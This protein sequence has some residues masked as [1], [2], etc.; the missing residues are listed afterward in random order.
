MT[1]KRWTV[2]FRDGAPRDWQRAAEVVTRATPRILRADATRAVRMGQGFLDVLLEESEAFALETALK[3]AGF[4]ARAISWAECERA[5]P[6]MRL[7]RLTREATDLVAG[8]PFSRVDVVHM[9]LAEPAPFFLPPPTS[10]ALHTANRVAGMVSSGVQLFGL[11]DGGF[12]AALE[13]ATD[14]AMATAPPATSQPE[15]VIE[16]LGLWAPRVHLPVDTFEYAT[17]GISGGRRSRVAAL[18]ELVVSKTPSARRLGLVQ[19]VLAQQQV[20]GQRPM[21]QADHRRFVMALLTGRRL[22]PPQAQSV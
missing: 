16:L 8:F 15:L 2:L 6:A 22:W 11:E 10:D 5:E 4:E 20:D 1:T 18:L 14:A 13:K 7:T 12:S 3:Q 19:Q 21:P 17:L 9:V